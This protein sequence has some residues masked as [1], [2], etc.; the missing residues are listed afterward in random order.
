MHAAKHCCIHDN[1]N[2]YCIQLPCE[3]C[4]IQILD[5]NMHEFIICISLTQ[6]LH[7]KVAFTIIMNATAFGGMNHL[8]IS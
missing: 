1:D 4:E 8:R 5:Y 2:Y 7:T 3:M 6:Q